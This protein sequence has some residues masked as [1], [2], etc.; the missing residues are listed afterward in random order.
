MAVI[1]ADLLHG[2]WPD[3][4]TSVNQGSVGGGEVEQAGL[5]G[6]ERQ[7]RVVGQLAVDA[8]VAGGAGDDTLLGG[9]GDDVLHGEA[10]ADLFVFDPGMGRDLV[11]D[12]QPGVDRLLL[13]GLGVSGFALL[14]DATADGG[15]GAVIDFGGGQRL[16]LQG[17]TEARLGAVDVLFG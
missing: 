7:G 8:E 3:Q 16:L 15:E 14:L 1:A 9:G 11:T 12:F 4:H 10:G 6:A 17:V 13:R 2:V 5:G